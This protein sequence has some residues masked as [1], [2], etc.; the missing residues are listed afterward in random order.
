MDHGVHHLIQEGIVDTQQLPVAGGPAQQTPQHIAP[1]FV[2]GQDAVADHEGGG[3]DVVGDDPQGH[4]PLLRLAVVSAGELRHLVGD[5]HHGV[6]VEEAVHVLAHAGQTLQ[7]HAGVD[8]LLLELG[9]VAVAIVVE[10]GEHVVPDLDVSVTVA[11]HGAA[12]LAAAVLRPTV[13]VDLGA[14]AAGTGAVLPEVVLLAEAEDALGGDAYLLVPDV[15]GLVVV[16]IDGGVQPV[17]LQPHHLSQELPAPCD[18]LMLEVVTEGEVAQHLEVGA[19]AGGLAHVLNVSCFLS[20][21]RACRC[22]C[23]SDR[24]RPG[25][26]AAPPRP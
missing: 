10:L 4:I 3:A 14:G 17:R 25:G 16:Q 7:A 20:S 23:T 18:G 1:P 5:I 9:V 21:H 11:A 19:V 22:G 12:G 6:H 13:I 15:E 8:V 2:G 24:C 26:G